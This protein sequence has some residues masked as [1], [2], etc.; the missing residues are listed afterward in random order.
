MDHQTGAGFASL[1]KS[2]PRAFSLSVLSTPVMHV[3]RTAQSASVL[4]L[5]LCLMTS[6]PAS[7]DRLHSVYAF[8]NHE[9]P[10]LIGVT[11]VTLFGEH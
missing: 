8:P 7:Y 6:N 10:L 4:A 5:C 2:R 1:Q 11:G 9:D 3:L